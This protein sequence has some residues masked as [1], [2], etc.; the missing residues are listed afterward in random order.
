MGRLKHQRGRPSNYRKSLQ[1]NAY[2]E[3]VK[4]KVRI[5][6][7]FQCV[8]CGGKTRLETHH[9]AYYVGGIP[10]I[11]RELGNLNWLA[12]LCERHH[13]AAHPGPAH[14]FNPKN[15]EKKDINSYKRF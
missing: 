1:E 15:P 9:I 12:T 10:V 4:R 3:K 14:P 11:G 6:D 7:N 8:V 2:W 5:R 13:A